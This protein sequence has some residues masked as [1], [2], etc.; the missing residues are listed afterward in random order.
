MIKGAIFDIDGTLYDYH[1]ND[2]IAMKKL[3]DFVKEKFGIEEEEFM[4]IYGRA[5]SIV[6]MRLTEGASQ[7]NRILFCQTALELI[8]QNPFIYAIDMYDIYWNT[9]LSEIKPF[10]GAI[11]FVRE[12][13]AS[14]IK[15]AVCTDMTAHIQFRKLKKLGFA[16]LIDYIVTSEET[17][18]EKPSPAMFNLALNKLEISP[19]NAAYFGDSPDRDIKGALDAGI[20][21]FW[22]CG[23]HLDEDINLDCVKVR[24]Y[25]DILDSEIFFIA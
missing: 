14:G 3:C 9:F 16:E 15:T 12:L 24:S 8:G 21:A 11:E 13:K 10:D 20:Q 2:K 18:L 22:Y 25:R 23:E 1:A 7:H 17:G 4:E 19:S 6:K 5:R